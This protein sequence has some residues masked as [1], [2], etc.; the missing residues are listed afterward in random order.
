MPRP[1]LV[2]IF[3]AIISVA[4][5]GQVPKGPSGT[6]NVCK[7]IDV[8]W[9]CV[10][11]SDTWASN[12]PFNILFVNSVP[13][14]VTFI[15]IVFHKQGADG[16]DTDFIN[17]FQQDMGEGNRKYA[18]VG[19][20]FRLPAGKYSVYI[21]GWDKRETLTHYGNFADYLAKTTLTVK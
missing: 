17:E 3:I 20:N 5:F 9:K 10:G 18:T 2:F 6:V 15:G 16:K 19:D 21:I 14:K 7:E 1:A 11:Q 13:V 4:A 12:T 8:D